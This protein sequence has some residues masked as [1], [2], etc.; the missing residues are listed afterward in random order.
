MLIPDPTVNAS[1]LAC[2]MR[3]WTALV[4]ILAFAAFP[5]PLYAQGVPA[6]MSKPTLTISSNDHSSA[7]VSWTKPNDNG[8]SI[9][10]F[11][12]ARRTSSSTEWSSTTVPATSLGTSISTLGGMN[13]WEI[14]YQIKVRAV[15]AS[16]DGPWSDVAEFNSPVL[17]SVSDQTWVQNVELSVTLPTAT[18][19][20]SPL[21]YS[22]GGSLPTGVTFT[23]STRVLAGTPSALSSATTYTYFATGS[24]GHFDAEKFTIEVTKL[25]LSGNIA[26]QSWVKDTAVSVTLPMASGGTAPLTYSV[27]GSLPTG[28]TFTAASRTL[29]GTPSAVQAAA[30]YTYKVEDKNGSE[31]TDEFTIAVTS[32]PAKM[33]TPTLTIVSTHHHEG[34][35]TWTAPS[36]NGSA[37]T[38]FEYDWRTSESVEW[39]RGAVPA[40]DRATSISSEGN[41]VWEIGYKVKI[42]AINAHGKGPWSD[43]AEFNSPV[44]PTVADQTWAQNVAFSVT[45][46]TASG[47]KS[48]Y[49]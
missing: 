30:T 1:H 8:S 17:P 27:V 35:I 28:V 15:N 39:S 25:T 33:S 31:D 22:L 6:K 42:R 40:A 24:N 34:R 18:G 16:G 45:L 14:G 9:T 3:P 44:L 37:I 5:F 32:V 29:S 12:Y 11:K 20:A 10:S 49:T 21:T 19:G 7:T 48:P 47:G 46:P 41:N 26:D 36:D 38:G 2:V 23:A 13:V 43:V 4:G